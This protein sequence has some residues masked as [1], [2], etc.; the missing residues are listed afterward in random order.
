MSNDTNHKSS[1]ENPSVVPFKSAF[2]LVII[3]VGLYLASVNFIAAESGGEEGEK[4]PTSEMKASEAG[5]EKTEVK[6]EEAAKAEPKK[7]EAA[8]PAEKK[9]EV[10]KPKKKHTEDQ[11]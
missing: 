9:E 6:T 4:K 3:L 5:T 8:K 1:N 2:W 11:Y 10:K 7:D